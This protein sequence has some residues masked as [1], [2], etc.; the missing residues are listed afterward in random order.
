METILTRDSIE[1]YLNYL[2]EKGLSENTIRAYR[3]DLREFFRWVMAPPQGLTVRELDQMGR[4]WLREKRLEVAPKTT[5]RR[6]TSLRTYARWKGEEVLKDY[7]APTPP[8]TEP[9]PIPEGVEGLHRMAESSNRPEHQALIGLCGFAGLRIGEALSI[10]PNMI[11]RR[12]NMILVR[13][14]G[15]KSRWVPMSPTCWRYIA[16]AYV[17]AM[18]ENKQLVPYQDR[19]ARKVITSLARRARLRRHVSSHDLRATFATAVYD[20]T[21]DL[22]LVQELLGHAS[23]DTTQIYT[24]VLQRKMQQAVNI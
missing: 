22:R 18:E 23:P 13:G 10:R 12:D 15:D 24:G 5:A 9:H 3:S 11:S 21:Q 8:R 1:E 20:S 4:K 16:S 2:C 19:F 17:A 14:K 7:S 6:L